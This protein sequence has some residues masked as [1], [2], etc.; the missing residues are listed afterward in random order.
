MV[1]MLQE[2]QQRMEAYLAGSE[3]EKERKE[4]TS[5]G[6]RRSQVPALL[7]EGLQG[8]IEVSEEPRCNTTKLGDLFFNPTRNKATMVPSLVSPAIPGG[9][10]HCS[11][12]RK[13]R[14]R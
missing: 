2:N 11:Q 14:G 9:D 13:M 12:Q 6:V 5:S 3:E 10:S 4:S 8:L 1:S 7:G